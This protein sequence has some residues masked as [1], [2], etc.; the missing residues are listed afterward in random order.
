[1]NPCEA[2]LSTDTTQF[3]E[4]SV[5]DFPGGPVAKA[6]PFDARGAGWIPGPEL[7]CHISHGQN[8]ETGNVSNIVTNSV[9]Q[10]PKHKDIVTKSIKT[11]KMAHIRKKKKDL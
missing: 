11:L 1:M 9:G 8:S 10:K 2:L 3:S 5:R 6:S 7:R 4:F